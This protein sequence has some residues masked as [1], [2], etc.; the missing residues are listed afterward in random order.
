MPKATSSVFCLHVSQKR[1]QEGN[2]NLFSS[3]FDRVAIFAL[4]GDARNA[5]FQKVG[6]R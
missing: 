3:S 5:R 4:V 6:M 2:K 1:H